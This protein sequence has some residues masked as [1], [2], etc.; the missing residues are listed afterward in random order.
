MIA[1]VY[2]AFSTLATVGYGD[3]HPVSN[4]ELIVGSF[5]IL[6][7]V[8][9]FSFIMGNFIDMLMEFKIVTSENEDNENLTKWLGLL[10]RFNKGRPLPKEMTFKIEEYFSYYWSKDR[11]YATKTL[12]GKRFLS[13]LPKQIRVDVRYYLNLKQCF[14]IYKDFLFKNFLYVFKNYF[15]MIRDEKLV[16]RRQSKFYG[17]GDSAWSAFMVAM[18]QNLEPRYFSPGDVIYNDMEE[19]EEIVF[20]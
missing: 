16:S 18:M 10:S 19:V 8:A 3:F 12:T 7:G 13:E 2:F 5:I 15:Q 1:C 14:Q 17:F 11:N 20:V 9:V 6:F 4:T